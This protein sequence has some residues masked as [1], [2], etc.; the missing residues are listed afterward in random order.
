MAV[1][2]DELDS[3]RATAARDLALSLAILAVVT[4]LALALRRSIT[5]P[6]RDVSAA[7]RGLAQGDIAAGVE[8]SSR[9]EI[10]DVA[11]AF[12]DVHATAARLVEEMRAKNRAVRENRL[13]HRADVSGLDGVWSQLVAGMNDTMASFVELQE[14]R[15]QAER[16]TA[17][18]FE[19]SL[20][21]LCVI[22]FDGYFK[23]VN[24]AF[25]QTLGYSREVL[26]SQRRVRFHP[27][28]RP[29]ALERDLFGAAGGS[30]G[31]AVREPQRLRRRLG[32][33]AAVERPS[34][35]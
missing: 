13:D 11:A 32:P 3:A 27:S 30:A 1:V 34:G 35:P 8:Y 9:D 29:R 14:R 24:P 5:R 7:A 22:G 12:R 23:R 15:E 26:L 33:L 20:D 17:R 6:L 21:L 10:G 28:G 2:S 31:R 4:A 16:E 18:I 19:M 25:E